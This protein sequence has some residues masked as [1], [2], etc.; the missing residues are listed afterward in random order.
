MKDIIKIS[1]SSSYKPISSYKQKFIIDKK[2]GDSEEDR[3]IKIIEKKWNTKLIKNG[4][5][6]II[7]FTAENDEYSVELKSRRNNYAKYPT[8]MIGNNK[9]DYIKKNNLTCIFVF[10]FLDG[11]YYYK[12]NENDDFKTDIGGRCDRGKPEFKKYYYIPIENLIK[13]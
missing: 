12:Y 10:A 5:S 4:E 7:D 6:S 8:T 3:I 13:L 9:I 1:K 2:L 11:D